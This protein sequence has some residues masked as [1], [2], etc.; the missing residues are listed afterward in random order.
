MLGD[1]STNEMS[2]AWHLICQCRS[3]D[4]NPPR[5]FTSPGISLVNTLHIDTRPHSDCPLVLQARS[6]WSTNRLSIDLLD[7]DRLRLKFLAV[8]VVLTNASVVRLTG[9]IHSAFWAMHALSESIFF[10]LTLTFLTGWFQCCAVDIGCWWPRCLK[11]AGTDGH[12][13]GRRI[14][15]NMKQKVWLPPSLWLTCMYSRE[16]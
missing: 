13:H 10:S 16:R 1:D 4:E 11:V 3:L 9:S 5:V 7:F 15:S 8:H 6:P 12:A 2:A 14:D